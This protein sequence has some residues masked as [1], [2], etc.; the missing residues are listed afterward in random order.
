MN[1]TLTVRAKKGENRNPKTSKPRTLIS[2]PPRMKSTRT[3]L[4]CLFSY[5]LTFAPGR[6]SYLLCLIMIS[7]SSVPFSI[8]HP[9]SPVQTCKHL[10]M[11]ESPVKHAHFTISPAT[12][13]LS[14]TRQGQEEGSGGLITFMRD[15]STSAAQ[16]E[17]PGREF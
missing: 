9:E 13:L 1:F 2:H 4:F 12:K 14:G 3:C 10:S 6:S 17:S 7:S 15:Y 11:R 16:R 8:F 5:Y